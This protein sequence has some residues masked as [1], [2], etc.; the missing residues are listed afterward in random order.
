MKIEIIPIILNCL[1]ILKVECRRETFSKYCSKEIFL[2]G[3]TLSC[4]GFESFRKLKINLNVSVDY[5]NFEFA[6]SRKLILDDDFNLSNILFYRHKIRIWFRFFNIKGID[7]TFT[8]SIYLKL[9]EIIAR[10]KEEK[11]YISL[12][13]LYTNFEFFRNKNLI[14]NDKCKE[15]ENYKNL[16]SLFN[17]STD[18]IFELYH[19]KYP[20]YEI[21]PFVFNKSQL[22]TMR[23]LGFRDFEGNWSSLHLIS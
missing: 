4:K 3:L 14:G 22:S 16:N 5:I 13:L 2:D 19:A 12:Y 6:S 15:I 9:N 1:L 7:F 18:F 20:D 11:T 21:C 23:I 17:R 10:V 8:Y